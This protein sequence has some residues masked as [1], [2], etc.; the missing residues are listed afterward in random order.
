LI[1][2]QNGFK[3]VTQQTAS[4]TFTESIQEVLRVFHAL[5][6]LF[7]LLKAYI[8]INHDI[9]LDK[10]NLYGLRRGWKLWFKSYLSNKLQFIE[11]KETNCSNCFK[12]SHTLSCMK[13]DHGVP[14]DSVLVGNIFFFSPLPHP[15]CKWSHRKLSMDK[16][17]HRWY[18][19]VNCQRKWIWLPT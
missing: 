3:K 17:I 12:N 15:I 7:D 13:M 8:V 5:G 6:L 11:I 19:F 10:L 1:E 16:V 9:L 18:Q 4:P 14:Q 2:A